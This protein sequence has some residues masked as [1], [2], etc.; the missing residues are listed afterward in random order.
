MAPV[1]QRS[2]KDSFPAAVSFCDKTTC[3]TLSPVF[4]L[5]LPTEISATTAT[6]IMVGWLRHQ[7]I[8]AV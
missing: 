5:A 4:S 3:R 6:A 1:R 8:V 7:Q 2:K